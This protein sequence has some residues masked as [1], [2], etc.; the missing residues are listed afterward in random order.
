MGYKVHFVGWCYRPA[1]NN[2]KIWGFIEFD[3]GANGQRGSLYNFWGKRGGTLTFER[4]F[5]WWGKD[6]LEGR[7]REKAN[8]KGYVEYGPHCARGY[9]AIQEGLLDYIE[10]QFTLAKFSGKVRKDDTENNSFI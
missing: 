2:D 7:Q 5:G 1:T 6:E 4:H 9:D 10:K 3:N 8:K